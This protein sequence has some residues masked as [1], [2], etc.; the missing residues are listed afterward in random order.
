M[1]R[2]CDHIRIYRHTGNIYDPF[3]NPAKN[4]D[5]DD[6]TIGRELVYEGDCK[7]KQMSQNSMMSVSDRGTYSIYINDNNINADIRDV[8]YL[9]SN[10]R[11]S[12]EIKL[13]I[14][15]VKR[16]ERNTVISAMHLKDGEHS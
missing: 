4:N 9:R 13:T 5:T 3:A 12:D 10:S 15:E 11:E 1:D 14:L 6:T 7:A 16:Y 2:F 8:A